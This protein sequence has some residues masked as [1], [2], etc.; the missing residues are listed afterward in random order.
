M[1]NSAYIDTFFSLITSEIT[2]NK[3]LPSFP[4]YYGSVNGIKKTFNYDIT[5]DYTNLRSEGWFYK[6]L[7]K[8]YSIDMY[9]SSD[10]ED[11]QSD[12]DQSNDESN[13]QSNDESNDI[14]YQN[15]DC[16]NFRNNHKFQSKKI[17]PHDLV[18]QG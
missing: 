16:T 1:D 6:N 18:L 7:G 4:I 5:D 10:E 9:V 11:N 12:S 8:T 3:I 15:D 2:L 17:V 13:G 14:Y